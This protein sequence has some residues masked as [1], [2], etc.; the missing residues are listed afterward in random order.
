ME[1][2]KG[3]VDIGVG[4]G[5]EDFNL[6]ALGARCLLRISDRGLVDRIFRIHQKADYLG[7]RDQV[8]QQV[9]PLLRQL[10]EQDADA[11][12]VAAWSRQTRRETLLNRGAELGKDDRDSRD[13][14]ST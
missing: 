6:D 9:D 2:G 14:K 1:G 3:G 11:G 7:L 13:R 8:G 12:E 10:V 4:A 5:F